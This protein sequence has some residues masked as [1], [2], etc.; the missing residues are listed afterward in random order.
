[1]AVKFTNLK[2][3]IQ[4]IR[5]TGYKYPVGLSYRPILGANLATNT[6]GGSQT[7]DGSNAVHTFSV[8]GTFTPS[9]TGTVLYFEPATNV[10]HLINTI[11]TPV[12]NQPLR[13][14]TSGSVRTLL[15][16]S[17]PDFVPG[18]GYLSYIEN[19]VGIQRRQTE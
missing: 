9:F 7:I 14:L 19:L 18:S 4:S 10:V 13:G 15:S 11:G 5:P 8:S 2:T 12:T 1:M 6:T 17:S 3:K 16:L